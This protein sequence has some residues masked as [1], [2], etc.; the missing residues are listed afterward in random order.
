MRILRPFTKSRVLRQSWA[1]GE[2]R[3][4]SLVGFE[5][6]KKG[7]PVLMEQD[8]DGIGNFGRQ[9]LITVQ[10]LEAMEDFRVGQVPAIMDEGL[11]YLVVRLIIQVFG[12][13]GGG[14]DKCILRMVL[15][16]PVALNELHLEPPL[17]GQVVRWFV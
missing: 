3:G 5:R 11:A 12:G 17:P 2:E 4:I 9:R 15:C 13:K 8:Q 14:I 16:D 10:V 7:D 6:L 1:S